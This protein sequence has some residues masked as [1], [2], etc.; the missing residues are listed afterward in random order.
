MHFNKFFNL[1][2]KLKYK[3][4]GGKRKK[5]EKEKPN[6][7]QMV[8]IFFLNVYKNITN[9]KYITNTNINHKMS[10]LVEC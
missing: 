9:D 5:K 4:E 1:F 10:T 8:T 7:R 6:K 3:I 2:P